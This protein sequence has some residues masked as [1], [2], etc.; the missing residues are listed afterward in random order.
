MD[1]K[2]HGVI[3]FPVT[4]TD[5]QGNFDA[6]AFR[7]L[8]DYLID[9]GVH[10][11]GIL[12]SSGAGLYFS[13]PERKQIASAAVEIIKGRVPL[14]VGTAALTT[15]ECIRLSQHAGDI[16]ADAVAINPVSYWPLTPEEVYRH[17]EQVAHAV[18]V[19]ICVYNNPRTTQFD[20]LPELAGRLSALPH[21]EN[22]KEISSDLG[23]IAQLKQSSGEAQRFQRP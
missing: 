17:F 5:P 14:L 20:I 6:R 11:L 12:A 4:P 13:E 19:A 3:A 15:A 18:G 1:V 7:V 21:I 10:G 22:I 23:R 2:F 9:A 8:I 16:G